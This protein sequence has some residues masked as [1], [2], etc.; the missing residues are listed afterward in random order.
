MNFFFSRS[1]SSGPIIRLEDCL[2]VNF[3]KADLKGDNMYSCEKCK[4]LREG[5]KY[6]KILKL[7]EVKS[8][9]F[10]AFK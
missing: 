3:S 10:F 8:S 6:L 2:T 9:F 1:F 5:I 7:P 4:N